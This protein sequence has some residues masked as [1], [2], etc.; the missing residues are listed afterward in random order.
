[1]REKLN[2]G[3]IGSKKVETCSYLCVGV[4][5]SLRAQTD[6]PTLCCVWQTS[7]KSGG[8]CGFRER[9]RYGPWQMLL[10]MSV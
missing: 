4:K 10:H 6:V 5:F 9:W 7:R 3:N 1:M 2:N 8:L